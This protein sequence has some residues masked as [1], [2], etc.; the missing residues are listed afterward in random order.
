M[1][2]RSRRVTR[3]GV[4]PPTSIGVL[5]VRRYAEPVANMGAAQLA[6]TRAAE[7]TRLLCQPAESLAKNQSVSPATGARPEPPMGV[8]VSASGTS[9][10]LADALSQVS[11]LATT[12]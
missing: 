4:A 7:A 10:A 3:S 12:A 9:V 6:R 8:P 5:S 11:E 1:T 2:Y